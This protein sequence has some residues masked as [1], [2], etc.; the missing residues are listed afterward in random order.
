MK[1]AE[2]L[3]FR[4]VEAGRT[5]I[6]DDARTGERARK[7]RMRAGLK[8]ADMARRMKISIGYVSDLELGHNRWTEELVLRY[9]RAL[10]R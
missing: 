4:P 7:V 2:K 8:L 5:I 10:N 9:I 3:T 6:Y 1:R